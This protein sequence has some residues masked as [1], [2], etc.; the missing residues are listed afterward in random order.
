MRFMLHGET[1]HSALPQD[2][3][4]WMPDHAIFFGVLYGVLAVVGCGL[5]YVAFRTF[6]DLISDH[7]QEH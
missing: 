7:S 4:W 6:R 2:I 5:A 3:P 1:L